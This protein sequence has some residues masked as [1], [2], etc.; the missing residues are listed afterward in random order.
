MER[1]AT[2]F[3]RSFTLPSEVDSSKVEA[4]LK[5][6]ILALTLPKIEAAKPKQITIN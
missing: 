2:S 4:S 5:D 3:S 1:A 6:G